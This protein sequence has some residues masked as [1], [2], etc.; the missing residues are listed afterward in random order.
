[1]TFN[2]A[3][4]VAY[5]AKTEIIAMPVMV[6]YAG[7]IFW[8]IGYDTIYACQ[9]IEDDMKIGIKSTA[10]KFESRIKVAV[11]MCYVVFSILVISALALIPLNNA[12]WSLDGFIPN[13]ISADLPI[14]MSPA[15]G[16]FAAPMFIHLICQVQ[17]LDPEDSS[18]CLQLFKSN[19]FAAFLL[20]GGLSFLGL[21]HLH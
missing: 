13:T 12:A 6:L 10:R 8:T 17:K 18:K 14:F 7:L 16:V 5:A 15:I 19:L 21:A 3:V 2:W 11:G 9:D 4:L 1:M 20:I